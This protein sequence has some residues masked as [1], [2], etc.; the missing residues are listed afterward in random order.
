MRRAVLALLSTVAGLVLVLSYKTH[1]FSATADRP[2]AIL[3]L[4]GPSAGSGAGGGG[5]GSGSMPGS[6]S[7]AM[8]GA[9]TY[10]GDVVNTA[11]GPVQVRITVAGHRLTAVTVLQAPSASGR[12]QQLAAYALPQLNQE[13]VAAQSASINVV[14]G[15]TY[16]SEGYL[17]SL[18]SALDRAGI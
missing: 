5:A 6:G 3:H 10:T 12:D 7:G 17:Q 13:A 18:Q 1:G 8:G 16:T 2:A 15:A 4:G 14:S 11:Y 9:T